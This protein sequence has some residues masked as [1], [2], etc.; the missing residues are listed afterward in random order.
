MPTFLF[1]SLNSS[2]LPQLYARIMVNGSYSVCFIHYDQ[3]SQF[4]NFSRY[5]SDESELYVNYKC[6][7]RP[8][9]EPNCGF[10]GNKVHS[11]KQ[12][13]S[14]FFQC[15]P[16]FVSTYLSWIIIAAAVIIFFIAVAL[17]GAYFTISSRKRALEEENKLWQ[18]SFNALVDVNRKVQRTWFL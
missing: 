9:D 1:Y 10:T 12:Q 2:N 5:Y 15:P 11:R 3:F 7:C 18:I 17:I 14:S 8:L 13:G 16:D 6:K 4:Q